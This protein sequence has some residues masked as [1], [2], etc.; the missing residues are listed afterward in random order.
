MGYMLFTARKLSLTTR[1]NQANARL[2]LISQHHTNIDNNIAQLQSLN[3]L[4]QT[5]ENTAAYKEY[6]EN[7]ASIDISSSDSA[8][9][10]S[11]QLEYQ[12]QLSQALNGI[13]SKH[14][15]SN[16][17][18]NILEAQA[19]QLD[20]QQKRLQTELDS[21]TAELKNVEEAEGKAIEASAPKFKTS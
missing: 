6:E 11:K 9:Y 12:I 7:M 16:S 19:S 5:K 13:S 2:M 15:M 4:K 8:S 21:M 3:A 10:L 18:I 20:I 17:Q 14:Q 1:I